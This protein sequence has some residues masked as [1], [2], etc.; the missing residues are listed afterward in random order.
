MGVMMVVMLKHTHLRVLVRGQRCRRHAAASTH[1][2]GKRVPTHILRG[3]KKVG[4]LTVVTAAATVPTSIHVHRVHWLRLAH[5][6]VEWHR[7][8]WRARPLWRVPIH[9]IAVRRTLG[10]LLLRGI[11]GHEG[12]YPPTSSHPRSILLH[13][14][15]ASLARHHWLLLHAVRGAH[16]G[17]VVWSI[18]RLPASSS[19]RPIARPSG[20]STMIVGPT[21]AIIWVLKLLLVLLLLVL[22]VLL[23]MLLLLLL[24]PRRWRWGRHTT[25]VA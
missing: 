20:V 10:L 8:P 4:R 25:H 7:G 3:R 5:A 24:M 22:M 6:S 12:W 15:A 17:I 1:A 2:H 21:H 19:S 11:H 18:H 14:S 13:H 9:V 16:H 23:R